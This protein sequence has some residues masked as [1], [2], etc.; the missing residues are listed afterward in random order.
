VKYGDGV[1]WATTDEGF[2]EL[3]FCDKLKQRPSVG[4]ILQLTPISEFEERGSIST[5]LRKGSRFDEAIDVSKQVPRETRL[6]LL[7]CMGKEVRGGSREPRKGTLP[8]TSRPQE[9]EY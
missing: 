7:V 2:A 4:R 1:P 6:I 5:M 8:Y 3:W 9:G